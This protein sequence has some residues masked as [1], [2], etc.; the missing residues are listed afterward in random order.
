MAITLQQSQAITRVAD[1][2]YPFLPG[3]RTPSRTSRFLFPALLD[4]WGWVPCGLAVARS[5]P[6]SGSWKVRWKIGKFHVPD[7]SPLNLCSSPL[8]VE[9]QCQPQ[10]RRN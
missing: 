6:S 3:K 2:L 8:K 5:L 7:N 1:V 9:V 4:G 10:K